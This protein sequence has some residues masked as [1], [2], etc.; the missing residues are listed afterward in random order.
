MKYFFMIYALL[1]ATV[2][3]VFGFRGCESTKPPLEVFPDMDRQAR[4]HEQGKTGFFEDGRMDRQPVAGVV[5][6]I[7]AEQAEYAHLAPD[8]R[9]RDD[10]YLVTGKQADGSFGD[11]IPVE[12]THEAMALGQ[13]SF[14][15][16]CAICHG[17]SGNGKGVIAD[18]RYN[19]GTIISIL[20][21]RIIDQPD[22]EIFNTITHGKNTMGAY[23]SKLTVEETWKVVMYVRAL[24]R[25]ATATVADV[26]AE[27]RGALGL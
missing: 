16:Y 4:F 3:I 1:V 14:N 21:Q 13:A 17:E 7:T 22:G 12:V 26:P 25:A 18:P 8:T 23:G 27:Q 20:Q 10:P 9:F 24:Q 2:L 19:Y 5:P 11:G 15:M 6:Y